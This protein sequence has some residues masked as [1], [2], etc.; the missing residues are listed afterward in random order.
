MVLRERKTPEFSVESRI[1]Q[2]LQFKNPTSALERDRAV[3]EA[4]KGSVGYEKRD[5]PKKEEKRVRF[6]APAPPPPPAPRAVR[7]QAAPPPAPKPETPKG[8]S[9]WQTY[10]LLALVIAGVVVCAWAYRKKLFSRGGKPSGVVAS[11]PV[12]V[13]AEPPRPAPLGGAVKESRIPLTL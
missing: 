8:G 13:K 9:G 1:F 2:P 5:A 12:A 10:A 4:R 7:S 6:E 3:L 11:G